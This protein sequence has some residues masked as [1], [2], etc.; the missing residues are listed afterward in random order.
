[1]KT[2]EFQQKVEEREDVRR[3]YSEENPALTGKVPKGYMTGEEFFRG[4]KENITKYY[5]ERGLL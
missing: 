4:I 3:H 5:K 2:V 1:M